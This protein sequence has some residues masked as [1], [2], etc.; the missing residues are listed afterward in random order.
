MEHRTWMYNRNYSNRQGLQEDFVEGVHD[1]IRHAM[2]LQSY[3]SEGVI[4]CPCVRCNCM[5]FEKPAGVKHHLYRKEFIANYF[6]WTNH[7]E[8]DGSYEIFHN[9][10]VGESSRSVENTNRDSRIHDMVADAFGMHLGGEPNENVKQTPNVDAKCFYEQLEEAS[11]PLR[12]GSPHSELSV[13]VRLLSIKSD[14]N[15]SQT[16]MDSFID[17]MSELVDY[18]IPGDFYKAK[19]LVSKLGLS[20]MK[21]DCYEDGCMLYYKDDANLSSYGEAWKHFDRTYPDFASEPRNI[22]LGLC[23]DGFMPFSVSVTPYSCWP[24]F[25]T[26]YNL[27]SELC[28]TSPY[29][30]LNCIIPGPRNPKGLIDVYLQTF[31]DELKQLWYDGVETYGIST[32]QNFNL[33][34]NLMCTINNFPAYGILF[35]WMT[36]GKLACPYCMENSKAFALKHGRKQS[37]FDCHRQFLPPDHEFRRMKNSFKKNNMEY[38]SPTLILSSDEIWERVQNFSKV[39]E[40]PPYR[41]PEYGTANNGKIFKPKASYTFTLEE[42]RQICDWVTKLKMP[43]G[44]ASNLGKKVDMEEKKLGRLMNQDELFKE[45]YIVKK[46]KETDQESQ[47]P[48]ESGEPI[49]PS[50]EDAGRMWMEAAGGPK[51]GKVY[52]LPTKKFH[53]YKC[54]IQGIGTSL[55]VE[56]LDEESLSAMRETVTKLTSKLEATKEREKL[57]DAQYIGMQAQCQGMQEKLKYLLASGGFPI[58]RSRESSPEAR[59]PRARS[60]C[61]PSACSSL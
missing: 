24:V 51:W 22:R 12:N 10:V 57:R 43:D 52:G 46:K 1:F 61:P 8:I 20:S 23:A 13:A 34:A 14:W 36:G 45:T 54:G 48:N 39:T 35:G 19:K 5:K 2:S 33:R 18:N 31:I 15:I 3:L 60:S 53:H 47:P 44:Y 50:D 6:V 49:Q 38:D 41:F 17:L 30:F 56:Q 58:S 59:L 26:P 29:I 21:I 11:R 16:T 7:G 42:R 4:R 27:P 37:W 32:K 9:M 25:L 40:A 55:Q 28:M